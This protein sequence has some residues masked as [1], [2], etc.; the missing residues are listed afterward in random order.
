MQEKN[1]YNHKG[2]A[3]S[4]I[5]WRLRGMGGIQY[6]LYRRPSKMQLSRKWE[7]ELSVLFPQANSKW[8]SVLSSSLLLLFSF[9]PPHMY[10]PTMMG[11]ITCFLQFSPTLASQGTAMTI[12]E[13]VSTVLSTTVI[14]MSWRFWWITWPLNT[15]CSCPTRD[16]SSHSRE[17][18]QPDAAINTSTFRVC[19][20]LRAPNWS[21]KV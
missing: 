9:I 21:S 5:N 3:F 2:S 19:T 14:M 13:M 15:V 17:V 1:V 10:V 7:R 18:A 11:K 16:S 20:L 6:H 8:R 12:I 4:T